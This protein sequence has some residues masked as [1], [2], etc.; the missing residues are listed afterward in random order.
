MSFQDFGAD[1]RALEIR[2]LQELERTG[3][4]FRLVGLHHYA[5]TAVV[6]IDGE[7]VD[8]I[9]RWH[10]KSG[11]GSATLDPHAGS[12]AVNLHC[13][14]GLARL[15]D[16]RRREVGKTPGI[17]PMSESAERE[18]ERCDCELTE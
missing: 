10:I 16:L 1:R 9:P 13:H 15:E 12:R 18:N 14:G 7:A 8:L 11:K 3:K 2:A 4:H 17:L 5:L 6:R